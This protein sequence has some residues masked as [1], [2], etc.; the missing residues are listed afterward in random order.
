MISLESKSA[1]ISSTMI[2]VEQSRKIKINIIR[3]NELKN[4]IKAL[5]LEKSA[6]EI[7]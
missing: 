5:G 1:S 6:E 7:L 4:A 2:R 3:P